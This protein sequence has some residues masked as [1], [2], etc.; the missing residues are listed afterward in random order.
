[1]C[2]ISERLQQKGNRLPLRAG[3]TEGGRATDQHVT[4]FARVT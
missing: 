4:I 3:D 2:R 1:M